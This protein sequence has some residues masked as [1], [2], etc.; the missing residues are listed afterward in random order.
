MKI[1]K[2]KLLHPTKKF[3]KKICKKNSHPKIIKRKKEKR[4]KNAAAGARRRRRGRAPEWRSP[5]PPSRLPAAGSP[6]R[7]PWGAELPQPESSP[8]GSLPLP[9]TRHASRPRCCIEGWCLQ[10]CLSPWGAELPRSQIR[11]KR[12]SRSGEGNGERWPEGKRDTN[13]VGMGPTM[14]GVDREFAMVRVIVKPVL[15]NL[16]CCQNFISIRKSQV[17]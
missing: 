17:R 2:K 3:G 4:K 14:L 7:S 5:P 16:C 9:S 11:R 13:H 8:L 12:K 10:A 1:L 15:A 6:R